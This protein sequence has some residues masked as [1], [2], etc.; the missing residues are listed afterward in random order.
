[1][2]IE[3]ITDPE[4]QE[5]VRAHQESALAEGRPRHALWSLWNTFGEAD[6]A[7]LRSLIPLRAAAKARKIPE[8]AIMRAMSRRS[9]VYTLGLEVAALRELLDEGRATVASG[10]QQLEFDAPETYHHHE[11]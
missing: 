7:A 9:S 8:D 4:L 11:H 3:D 6:W 2:K 1:M 5:W 10:P